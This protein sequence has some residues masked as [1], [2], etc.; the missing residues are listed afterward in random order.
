MTEKELVRY[1]NEAQ[2]GRCGYCP[3]TIK[4]NIFE[5]RNHTVPYL[6]REK[7]YPDSLL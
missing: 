6:E 5:I 7:D 1:C 2:K 4:C 3:Y